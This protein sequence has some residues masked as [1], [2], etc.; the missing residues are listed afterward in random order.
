MK[1]LSRFVVFV[2]LL[3]TV[4]TVIILD[5]SVGR[6]ESYWCDHNHQVSS[7]SSGEAFPLPVSGTDRW[8]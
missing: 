6:G 5:S 2:G 7:G 8:V 1:H 4:S 3:N